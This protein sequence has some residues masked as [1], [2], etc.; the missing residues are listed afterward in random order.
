MNVK[1]H[2]T[3]HSMALKDLPKAPLRK[4]RKKYPDYSNLPRKHYLCTRRP[5]L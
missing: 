2:L 4:E 1:E 5:D 3:T